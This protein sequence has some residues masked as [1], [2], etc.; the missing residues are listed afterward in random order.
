MVPRQLLLLISITTTTDTPNNNGHFHS[1]EPL[2]RPGAAMAALRAFQH[3][4]HS[5]P[6]VRES[7][8]A[9]IP[10]VGQDTGSQ[11]YEA[12][13]SGDR[14]WDRNPHADSEVGALHRC[15]WL[16]YRNPP[17]LPLG[18]SSSGVFS[19]TL[20]YC[21]GGRGRTAVLQMRTLRLWRAR[22][23]LRSLV[24]W[25]SVVGLPFHPITVAAGTEHPGWQ[26]WGLTP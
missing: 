11:R 23:R 8:N 12:A 4:S 1:S 14:G 17:G 24:S 20:H 6:R 13:D 5:V 7:D 26:S 15:T 21:P 9:P 25:D 22:A 19:F 2:L 3:G 16:S 18:P 10:C